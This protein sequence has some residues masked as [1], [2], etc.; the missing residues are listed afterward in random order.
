MPSS[1]VDGRVVGVVSLIICLQEQLARKIILGEDI[2]DSGKVDLPLAGV[3]FR[4]SLQRGFAVVV[5]CHFTGK[6]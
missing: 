1:S 5:Y 4:Y 6:R 3:D 2:V